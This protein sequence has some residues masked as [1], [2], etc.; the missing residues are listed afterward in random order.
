[1]NNSETKPREHLTK[2]PS[3]S[4]HPQPVLD[5]SLPPVI[6]RSWPDDPDNREFYEKDDEHAD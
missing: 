6:R 3:S 2:G 1:M 5:R 4:L